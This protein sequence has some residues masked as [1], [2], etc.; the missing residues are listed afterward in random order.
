[1]SRHLSGAG[2]STRYQRDDL[3][4]EHLDGIPWDQAPIPGRW[5]H[6]CKPQTQGWVN[7]RDWSQICACGATRIASGPWTQRHSRN[8]QAR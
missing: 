6:F 7:L 2:K 1:V 8:G 4:W 3:G 5:L